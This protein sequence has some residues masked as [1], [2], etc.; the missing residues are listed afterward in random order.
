MAAGGA[1]RLRPSTALIR[2]HS[3]RSAQVAVDN[4]IGSGF[5]GV[6]ALVAVAAVVD[7]DDLRSDQ[8]KRRSR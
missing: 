7:D 3:S 5:Q 4:V 8:G 6:D 1:C 2:D